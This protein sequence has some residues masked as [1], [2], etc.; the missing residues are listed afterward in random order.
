[1]DSTTAAPPACFEAQSGVTA[2][3]SEA[4]TLGHVQVALAD[5]ACAGPLLA[6]YARSE[7]TRIAI[8]LDETGGSHEPRLDPDR[9]CES[10]H[11]PHQLQLL[12]AGQQ[13]WL[14]SRGLD[15]TRQLILAFDWKHVGACANSPPETRLRFRDDRAL[16]LARLLAAELNANVEGAHA[17]DR[18]YA[19]SL[20]LALIACVLRP[21][22]RRRRNRVRGLN[23]QQLRSATELL[24]ENLNTH[25][26]LSR[27]AEA[28]GLSLSYFSHAFKVSTGVPPHR[29]QLVARV[30]RAQ[31]L[32]LSRRMPLADI[33]TATGFADQSHFTRVFRKLVGATPAAWL[34]ARRLERREL[35]SSERSTSQLNSSLRTSSRSS[36]PSGAIFR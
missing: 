27:L 26:E 30:Q 13:A 19:D 34:R 18:M 4:R 32:L 24:R 20:A 2:L 9:P 31:E 15:Y 7:L 16:A 11:V 29:W 3:H 6:K 5:F 17:L 23:A 12:A 33:A 22:E 1:M 36:A 25:V 21:E 8:T 28:T 35:Q 14:Y 10:P